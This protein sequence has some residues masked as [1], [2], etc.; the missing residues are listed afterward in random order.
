MREIFTILFLIVAIFC[1]MAAGIQRLTFPGEVAEIEQIRSD[2]T[3][4]NPATAEDVVGQ[5]TAWNQ[6]IRSKKAYNNL[7]W[8][9][10][11]IPDGWDDIQYIPVP[12]Q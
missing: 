9:G 12:K 6:H 4:L 8:S 1:G 7:W 11:A 5:I 3:H 2:S 10:W